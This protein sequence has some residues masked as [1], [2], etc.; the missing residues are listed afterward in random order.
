MEEIRHFKKR[1]I[2][3]AAANVLDEEILSIPGK[4]IETIQM[5]ISLS[6]K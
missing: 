4:D 3:K 6:D 5:C 2:D 1:S